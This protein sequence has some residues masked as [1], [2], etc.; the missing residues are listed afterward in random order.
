VT[1]GTTYYGGSPVE[2][3][4]GLLA[5]RHRTGLR[6]PGADADAGTSDGNTCRDVNSDQDANG[7]AYRD[8][9][10]DQDAD[11]HAYRDADSDQDADGRAY[12]DTDSD[13]DAD[14]RAY[15]DT[16]P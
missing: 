2:R 16:N 12:R 10:S 1:G 3:R 11:G 14:G 15:R 13:Q 9:N 8:A 7:H 5:H 6:Q 4:G